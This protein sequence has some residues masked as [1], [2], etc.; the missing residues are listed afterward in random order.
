[1]WV[2]TS[3]SLCLTPWWSRTGSSVRRSIAPFVR[4]WPPPNPLACRVAPTPHP[5]LWVVS[6][7]QRSFTHWLTNI[8]NFWNFVPT[9]FA[10]EN[11]LWILFAGTGYKMSIEHCRLQGQPPGRQAEFLCLQGELHSSRVAS[12]ILV[13]DSIDLWGAITS[14]GWYMC[15]ATA[16][17]FIYSFSGNC[18]ASA[19]ISSFMCLWAIYIFAASVHIFPPS[20]KADPLW[21]Y[22]I[23]S[24]THEC[25]NWDWDP[26]IPFLGI[27]ICFKFSAFCL[28]S[29]A[30]SW[31]SWAPQL[32]HESLQLHGEPTVLQFGLKCSRVRP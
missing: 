14:P 1:M 32:L 29:V 21:E 20:E 26:D 27:C 17:P 31:Y 11:T 23:R 16:I 6:P 13:W 5:H 3:P 4:I 12:T 30:Q 28:C 24:Q 10:E 8:A 22:I 18:A 25:G 2:Q 9:H 19:S 7:P 15:T